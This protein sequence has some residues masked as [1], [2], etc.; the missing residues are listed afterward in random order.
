MSPLR[1]AIFFLAV[2]VLLPLTMAG[3]AAASHLVPAKADVM[4]NKLVNNY[5]QTISSAACTASGR[6]NGTHAPPF[7]FASCL[8]PAFLPGTAAAL[9]PLSNSLVQLDAIQDDPS[10]ATDEADIGLN[11]HLK[12]V[13]CLGTSPGCPGFGSPYDPNPGPGGNDVAV[14]FRVRLSDHLNCSGSACT[15]FTSAGTVRDFDLGFPIDCTSVAPPASCDTTTTLNALIPG[16]ITRGA[17]LNAQVFRIRVADSGLDGRLGNADDREF[18]MQGLVV[19][20]D[21]APPTF[22]G[23]TSA[24]TCIPGP[25]GPPGRTSSH[26]LIWDPATDNVTPSSQIVYDIYQATTPGGEN[27]SMPTYTTAPGATAFDTPQLSADQTFYFVV[28]ARDQAGNEDSNTVE[29]QGQNIC[30]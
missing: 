22:A 14:R 1:K 10:T 23:L 26:H 15:G 29:R 17:A 25:I 4:S 5:R 3:S 7:T 19:D 8:P 6:T 30:D 9:G 27:F 21:H 12:N 28:R 24:T 13:I 16:A 2:C 20:G 18:A 11:G